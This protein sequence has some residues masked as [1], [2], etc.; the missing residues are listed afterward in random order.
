MAAST[1]S[2][3][4]DLSSGSAGSS[5]TMPAGKPSGIE[6]KLS[7]LYLYD[8]REGED[9]QENDGDE[10][11]GRPLAW[12]GLS[13][14]T[15]DVGAERAVP[16]QDMSSYR[17]I[18]APCGAW[19][20]SEFWTKWLG[21]Q[22]NS[23][24]K[25]LIV[26][27]IHDDGRYKP[28]PKLPERIL[29]GDEVLNTVYEPLG[30]N[31]VSSMTAT[32]AED[33]IRIKQVD[34]SVF[35][36]E[37]PLPEKLYYS[38]V[39]KL[40]ER[41]HSYLT[42]WWEGLPGTESELAA[43][44]DKGG[45]IAT[46]YMFGVDFKKDLR[47]WRINPFVFLNSVFDTGGLPRIEPNLISGQR[48]YFSHVDGDGFNSYSWYR[49]GQICGQVLLDEIYTN[50]AYGQL[51]VT[52]SV[53]GAEIDENTTHCLPI[54]KMVVQKLYTLDNVEAATHAYAH[55][56]DW[57]TRELCWPGIEISK[58]VYTYDVRR[59]TVNTLAMVN[60]LAPSEK[61]ATM[62]LWSGNCNPDEE[63]LRLIREGGYANMNGGDTRYDSKIPSITGIAPPSV[64][65]G[66]EIRVNTGEA[67]DYILTD[68][69]VD[70][71]GFSALIETFEKSSNPLL[72][73]LNIYYHFYA[74]ERK[75][76]LIALK[77]NLN[78]VL[79]HDV[80]PIWTSDYSKIIVASRKAR[81][82]RI[83]D[84]GFL[85]RQDGSIPTLRF[86]DDGSGKI[87]F[88][89]LRRCKGVTGWCHLN[90]A[91]YVYLDGSYE[92]SIFL[93]GSKP[94]EFALLKANRPV[95]ALKRGAF[96]EGGDSIDSGFSFSSWG[97]PV[98]TFSFQG[99][100]PSQT[101]GVCFTGKNGKRMAEINVFS[102]ISGILDFS[103]PM[104]E[105]GTINVFPV[106]AFDFAYIKVANYFW[107][108]GRFYLLALVLAVVTLVSIRR[109]AMRS[110]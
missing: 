46:E 16:P 110:R 85:I 98:G 88:P 11:F 89:D 31:L 81:L 92:Q 37:A 39:E 68:E 63:A 102:N 72:L 40:S 76:A 43:F 21:R 50:A 51:P 61:P 7:I 30:F 47:Y 49:T 67:N 84:G 101:Y 3:N 97:P 103:I 10:L 9:D 42:L 13:L 66:N 108:E 91:L 71:G 8:S 18:I 44:S 1:G 96:K 53:I 70:F 64:R 107:T 75:E 33:I 24:I 38:K 79:E 6:E 60:N 25:V 100:P 65:V 105:V 56:M 57:R 82:Y 87:K 106:S 28:D 36:F 86:D 55:P 35:G 12:L 74:G 54:T 69:W 4:G 15:L 26:S 41:V 48:T 58:S 45:F 22:I 73:P 80:T 34:E 83:P 17:G 59:E 32:A 19:D 52:L 77:K 93:S 27:T 94:E 23:G 95:L 14:D 109:S 104:S 20:T 99:L 2:L 5:S 29:L 90:E 62:I 78:W